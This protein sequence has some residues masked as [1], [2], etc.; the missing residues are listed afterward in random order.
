MK[1]TQSHQC[2]HSSRNKNSSTFKST[3]SQNPFSASLSTSLIVS[4]LLMGIAKTLSHKNTSHWRTGVYF[5]KHSFVLLHR[6]VYNYYDA[7]LTD[8]YIRNNTIRK[9]FPLYILS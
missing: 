3:F 1:E 6:L 8:L 5:E 7:V 4:Y 2:I 9:I